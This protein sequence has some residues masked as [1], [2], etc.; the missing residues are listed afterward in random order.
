MIQGL[1]AA[2]RSEIFVALRSRATLILCV[3]PSLVAIAQ[4]LLT[5]TLSASA[6]ARDVLTGNSGFGAAAQIEGADAWGA[7]VDALGSGLA[8]ISLMLVAY[9]AWSFASDRDLGV[10]RHLVIRRVSRS[11]LVLGKLIQA[12]LLALSSIVLLLLSTV[13]VA[14][15]LWDFGPVVEEGYELISLQEIRS[16]LRLGLVLALIPIP[17]GIALGIMISVISNSTTQALSAALGITLGLDL[18]KSVLGRA[19][20]YLYLSYQVSLVDDSYLSDVARLV[21][22]YSD[23]MLQPEVMQLNQWVPWP[24][25]LLFMAVALVLVNRKKL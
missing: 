21:R 13:V 20:D 5:R 7:L 6:Q 16:E 15:V 2:V 1:A 12:H 9:A 14:S 10:A 19:A 17:A 18:F 22:G 8:L 11:A 24:Q 25:M 3:L 4:L 23:V